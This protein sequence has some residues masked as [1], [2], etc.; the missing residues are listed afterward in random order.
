MTTIDL[1]QVPVLQ[2]TGYPR[3]F[4]QVGGNVELRRWQAVGDAAGLTQFGVNRVVLP[5]GAMS[6][7]RHWH[8]E[9]DEFVVVLE[10][11]LVLVTDAGETTIGPGALAGFPKGRANGH[12]LVNRAE[13]DAVFLAIG[14][15]SSTDVCHYSDVDMKVDSRDNRYVTRD[16][17]PYDDVG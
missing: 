13:S 14:T 4:R 12:H 5:P 11:E 8:T 7:L 16:G 3:R 6:S 2:R 17:T 1:A 9:E 10:G 15:R